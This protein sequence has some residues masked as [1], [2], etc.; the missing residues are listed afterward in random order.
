MNYAVNIPSSTASGNGNT[1]YFQLK[2][3]SGT[4][5]VGLG[6][7]SQMAGANIFMVYAA[8]SSNVTL[9][10]RLGTGEQQPSYP[11]TAQIT[12]LD[13]TEVG[14]DG[15]MTANVRCDNC[16]SWSGGSMSP[17]DDNS[18]WIWAYK[19]GNP[20]DS[21]DPKANLQQHDNMGTFSFNLKTATGGSSSNPF[22]AAVSNSSSSGSASSS[23]MS[24]GSATGSTQTATGSTTAPT[25]AYTTSPASSSGSSS[26]SSSSSND[27]NSTRT[28][29]GV[30]MSITFLVLMPFAAMALYLPFAKRVPFVHA[31][32]QLISMILLIVGLATGVSLGK[33][34]G[35]TDGYH[36][37]IGYIIV[38][39][40]IAVQPAMGIF[41]HL[42]C[43]KTGE[44]SS[45]GVAHQWL[46]RVV[47][48]FG[49]VNGGLGMMQ[50]GP[51]GMEYVPNW[52][53]VAYSVVALVV[54]LLYLAL[55]VG[56][57]MR[58]WN[59]SLEGEKRNTRG[60]EMHPPSPR[61]P[62]NPA[63]YR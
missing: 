38:A 51:A 14:S 36:Q 25:S 6:Q 40:L 42:H 33:S 19:N 30:V 37:I 11:S 49:V 26:D 57:K 15:S 45:L 8:S 53:V 21:T 54:L 29:H 35:K 1:I 13:G 22:V 47:I 60:Y 7:G 27:Q 31:P 32:M 44:R 41:Q 63:Q 52:A 18:A 20:I 3:P 23:A 34:I 4:Q 17:T 46:G 55:V 10:N 48:L 50:A 43:R 56:T 12:L 16:L 59:R 9:S 28:A 39:L 5:W 62:Y 24:S 2:A 58:N 61:R